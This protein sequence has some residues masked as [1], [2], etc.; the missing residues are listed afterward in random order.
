MLIKKRRISKKNGNNNKKSY[1]T[2]TNN[3]T[4]QN[5]YLIDNYECFSNKV[6]FC[7][8]WN[9]SLIYKRSYN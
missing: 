5:Y 6:K 9:R 2:K 1:S 8:F 4:N 3:K 7:N